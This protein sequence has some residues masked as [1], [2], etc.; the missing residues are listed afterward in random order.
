M[1]VA[2]K[3]KGHYDLWALSIP[4][5]WNVL[6]KDNAGRYL[7]WNKA[8]L[9]FLLHHL[10]V[11]IDSGVFTLQE[12]LEDIPEVMKNVVTVTK[13]AGS[14]AAQSCGGYFKVL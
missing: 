9:F 14:G 4:C 13:I 10:Q 6:C 8:I 5:R 12:F 1:L 2:S 11:Q 3:Q 7:I